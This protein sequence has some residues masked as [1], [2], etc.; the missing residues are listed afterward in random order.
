MVTFAWLLIA[1]TL[2]IFSSVAYSIPYAAPTLELRQVEGEL[3]PIQNGIVYPNFTFQRQSRKYV[4]LNGEWEILYDESSGNLK[5]GGIR[6][7]LA[8]RTPQAL[9]LMEQ[10]MREALAKSEW[11][12]VRVPHSNNA[13]GSDTEGYQGVVWYR[14]LFEMPHGFFGQDKGIFLVFHGVNY[15]VDVWLNGKYLG[16]HEG[17]FTPFLFDATN[18]LREGI[19]ELVLRVDNVPWDTPDSRLLTVPYRKCD[20]WNYGGVYRDVYI[21]VVNSTYIARLD[22]VALKSTEGWILAVKATIVSKLATKTLLKLKL[23]PADTAGRLEPDASSLTNGSITVA[24]LTEEVDLN[25]GIN[26]VKLRLDSI[27]VKEWCPEKP[28]LYVF[29]AEL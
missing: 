28:N 26:L 10:Q 15:V 4:N 17:G 12:K 19:N 29:V 21:E 25:S 6:L 14:K 22:L 9:E 5:V 8:A 13:R 18:S 16:Y 27:S 11:R 24:E 1:A 2:L 7:S 20:W 23:H 3:V